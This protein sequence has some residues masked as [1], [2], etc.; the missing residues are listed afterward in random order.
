MPVSGVVVAHTGLVEDIARAVGSEILPF[1]DHLVGKCLTLLQAAENEPVFKGQVLSAMGAI[2]ECLDEGDQCLRYTAHMLEAVAT[3]AAMTDGPAKTEMDADA[4]NEL[5]EG[6]VAAY[7]GVFVAMKGVKGAMAINLKELKPHLAYIFAYVGQMMDDASL[8]DAVLSSVSGL[9]GDIASGA[10]YLG[11]RRA[12]LYPDVFD[13][14]V[15]RAS[16]SGDESTLESAQYCR[17][18]FSLL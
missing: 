15:A 5:R 9:L 13:K 12:D 1:C 7:A 10:T 4:R 14:V 16:A 18:K 3:Q 2:I 17:K 8:S 11:K 6:C